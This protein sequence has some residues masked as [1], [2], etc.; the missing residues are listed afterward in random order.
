MINC[1]MPNYLES[2]IRIN[3][4]KEVQQAAYVS[5]YFRKNLKTLAE[6]IYGFSNNTGSFI[7]VNSSQDQDG[8]VKAGIIVTLSIV[9]HL[10]DILAINSKVFEQRLF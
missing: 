8:I 5:G 9:N 2:Y 7:L 4:V 1:F 6:T 10:F 3:A